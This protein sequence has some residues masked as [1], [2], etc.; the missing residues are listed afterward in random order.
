MT[1]TQVVQEDSVDLEVQVADSLA[2]EEVLEEEAQVAA[3]KK[4]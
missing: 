1:S 2:E 4:Q 3:G